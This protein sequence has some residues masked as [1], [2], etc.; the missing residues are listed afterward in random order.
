ML[1]EDREEIL[2]DTVGKR[3]E[4]MYLIPDV[5]DFVDGNDDSSCPGGWFD[6]EDVDDT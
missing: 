3:D 1:N 2:V 4:F 5:Y 6:D